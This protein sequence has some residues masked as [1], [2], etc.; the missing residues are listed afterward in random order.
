M[1]NPFIHREVVDDNEDVEKVENAVVTTTM[2]G[3]VEE[4]EDSAMSMIQR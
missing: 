3:N 4:E 1:K 2:V